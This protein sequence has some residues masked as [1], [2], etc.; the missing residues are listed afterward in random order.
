MSLRRKYPATE[1]RHIQWV[2]LRGDSMLLESSH[3]QWFSDGRELQGFRASPPMPVSFWCASWMNAW[4]LVD[5]H[6]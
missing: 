3:G 4:G 2:N 5:T 1:L 6:L